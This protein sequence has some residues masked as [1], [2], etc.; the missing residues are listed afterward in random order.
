MQKAKIAE[1]VE[2]Y[3]DMADI[4]MKVTQEKKVLTNEERNLLSVA[5][6]NVVGCLRNAWRMISHKTKLNPSEEVVKGCLQKIEDELQDI[7]N[8][9]LVRFFFKFT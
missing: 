3:E 1:Q 9:V 5:Y 6:K 8:N 7:C 4:M 2:R